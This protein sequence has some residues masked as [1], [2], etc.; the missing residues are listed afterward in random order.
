MVANRF[1]V[2]I[3]ALALAPACGSSDDTVIIVGGDPVDDTVAAGE[4]RGIQLADQ[5]FDE[6]VGNDYLIQ[7][8]MTATILASLHDGVINEADF[9]AQLVF[10]DDIFAFANDLILDHE[11][12][13]FALDGVVRFYGVGFVPTLTADDLAA[14]S[15]ANVGFLRGSPDIDFAFVELEVERAAAAGILLDELYSIVGPGEMGNHILA[16]MDMVDAHLAVSTSLLA[17]FY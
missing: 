4:A 10:D 15:S 12:A 2:A 16:D 14:E 13:N 11:D 5:S 6:L 8:G 9:A 17:T 3:A 1:L 7:I